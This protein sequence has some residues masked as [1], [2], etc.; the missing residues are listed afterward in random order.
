MIFVTIQ[1]QA[2]TETAPTKVS[3]VGGMVCYR[4]EARAE[5]GID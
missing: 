1:V 2:Y 5:Y 3:Y 4:I